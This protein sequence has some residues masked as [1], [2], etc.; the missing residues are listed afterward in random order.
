MWPHEIDALYR[1]YCTLPTTIVLFG[2]VVAVIRARTSHIATWARSKRDVRFRFDENDVALLS[3]FL[4]LFGLAVLKSLS[5][6]AGGFSDEGKY[7]AFY[8]FTGLAKLA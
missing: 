5:W 6:L 7:T 4:W 1:W 8:V 2:T 3:P